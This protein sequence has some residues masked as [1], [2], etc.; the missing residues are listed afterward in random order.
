[1]SSESEDPIFNIVALNVH[2]L[3]S[4]MLSTQNIVATP[5]KIAFD[6]KN[7]WFSLFVRLH[8]IPFSE[9]YEMEALF[10]LYN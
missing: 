8:T 4:I 10:L 1:M 5:L 2:L 6:A 3:S 7:Y 9:V